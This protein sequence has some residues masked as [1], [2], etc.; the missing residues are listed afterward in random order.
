MNVE[1]IVIQSSV[2]FETVY[3]ATEKTK[4]LGDTG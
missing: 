3:S 4:F 2:I 1:D